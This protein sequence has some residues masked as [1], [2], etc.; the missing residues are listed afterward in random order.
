MSKEEHKRIMEY[1]EYHNEFKLSGKYPPTKRDILEVE[2]RYTGWV[3]ADY[4][5]ALRI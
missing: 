2:S 5:I 4:S 1:M 3:T